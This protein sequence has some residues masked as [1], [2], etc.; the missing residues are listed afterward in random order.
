MGLVLLKKMMRFML[1]LLVGWGAG[2]ILAAQGT[3]AEWED[4]DKLLEDP[5]YTPTISD[6]TAS[7]PSQ[8]AATDPLA[9][10]TLYE[11]PPP[12]PPLRLIDSPRYPRLTMDPQTNRRIRTSHPFQVQIVRPK[13]QN[14]KGYP[15]PHG[16]DT[17]YLYIVKAEEV[18]IEGK[19]LRS[20]G[21]PI[22][23]AIVSPAKSLP[24]ELPTVLESPALMLKG[25]IDYGDTIVKHFKNE[26]TRLQNTL[27]S[28]RLLPP[29]PD[30]YQAERFQELLQKTEDSLHYAEAHHQLYR[31]FKSARGSGPALIQFFLS[32]PLNRDLVYSI[33]ARPYALP[34]YRPASSET[35]NRKQPPKAP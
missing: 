19:V 29:P 1:L 31:A 16:F 6:T 35:A 20:N 3:D 11:K 25:I 27:D 28:L 23:L 18:R 30:E 17:Y 4:L 32:Y 2:G 10:D 13:L 21:L 9:E 26:I 33:Y 12:P 22:Y 14:S 7:P 5:F 24:D 34:Q 8:A 15:L